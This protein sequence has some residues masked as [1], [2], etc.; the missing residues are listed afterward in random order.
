[1]PIIPNRNLFYC[2]FYEAI[3]EKYQK[4]G[5]PVQLGPKLR[6][7]PRSTDFHGGTNRFNVFW[8]LHYL[9]RLEISVYSIFQYST[10]IAIEPLKQFAPFFHRNHRLSA[11][12]QWGTPR[13]SLFGKKELLYSYQT[14]P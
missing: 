5:T 12:L 1:L 13:R 10:P 4:K 11:A 7:F 3:K 6:D 14:C 8:S 2:T 9:K